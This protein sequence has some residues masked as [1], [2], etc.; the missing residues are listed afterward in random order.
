QLVS[1]YR[2][3]VGKNGKL[4]VR[5][6]AHFP[7]ICNQFLIEAMGSLIQ[8]WVLLLR[9]FQKFSDSHSLATP[10]WP[11]PP[12]HVLNRIEIVITEEEMPRNRPHPHCIE[13]KC[14]GE[15]CG[16]IGAPRQIQIVA[17][18]RRTRGEGG[19]DSILQLGSRRS[20][21]LVGYGQQPVSPINA[22]IVTRI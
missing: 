20:P 17:G 13:V 11:Q 5:W 1:R 15:Y 6:T 21:G 4:G 9:L 18:K 3:T 16:A 12:V 19:F 10:V 7:E 14:C 22:H 8:I 2:L